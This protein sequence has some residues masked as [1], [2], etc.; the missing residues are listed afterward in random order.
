MRVPMGS[1][2]AANLNP[3]SRF[4]VSRA[5]QLIHVNQ[6]IRESRAIQ[7]SRT[8]RAIQTSRTSRA[9]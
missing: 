6:L 4:P 9:I 3:G 7:T 8:S 5:I 2:A 1:T